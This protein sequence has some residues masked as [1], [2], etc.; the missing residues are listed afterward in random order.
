[1][2]S[3]TNSTHTLRAAETYASIVPC[4]RC[5]H[6]V[7][8][9]GMRRHLEVCERLPDDATLR[10][11]YGREGSYRRV[12]ALYGVHETTVRVRL[13]GR[14]RTR[15]RVSTKGKPERV[16]R[17]PLHLWDVGFIPPRV[18][19]NCTV[20]PAFSLC[21]AFVAEL[22]C[23]LCEAPDSLQLERWRGQN[24]AIADIIQISSGFLSPNGKST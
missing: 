10:E 24:L 4:P 13:N 5:G 14:H 6:L 3:P 15:R 22:G 16:S 23:A 20:C 1:M 19:A 17:E 18:K 11:D 12:A 8:G 9:H 7:N 2:I 21:K